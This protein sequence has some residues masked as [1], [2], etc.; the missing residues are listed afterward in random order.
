M[1][2]LKTRAWKRLTQDHPIYG[3]TH[4]EC[5]PKAA[6]GGGGL[7]GQSRDLLLKERKRM[8]RNKT[9][10]PLPRKQKCMVVSLFKNKTKSRHHPSPTLVRPPRVC[11]KAQQFG[12][13][14]NRRRPAKYQSSRSCSLQTQWAPGSPLQRFALRRR[15]GP[16]DHRARRGRPQRRLLRHRLSLPGGLGCQSSSPGPAFGLQRAANRSQA[17]QR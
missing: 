17:P 2:T 8:K 16:G 13:R 15:R 5:K 4:W 7:S 9:K 11:T 3:Q 6:P 1:E 14:G 10:N 12:S